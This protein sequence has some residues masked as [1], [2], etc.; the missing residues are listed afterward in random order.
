MQKV[1]CCTAPCTGTRALI[2]PRVPPA[3]NMTNIVPLVAWL[4]GNVVRRWPVDERGGLQGTTPTPEW[5]TCFA[6]YLQDA[7]CPIL[8]PDAPYAKED[9]SSYVF[10]L[11]SHA[12]AMQYEDSGAEIGVLRH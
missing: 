6:A 7:A 1:G 4:E 12:L 11:V 3:G 9:C 10:W 8:G 5:H 2:L